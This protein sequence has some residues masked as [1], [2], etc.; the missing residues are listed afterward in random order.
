MNARATTLPTDSN[1]R[2][3]V[4]LLRG[5]LRYAPAALAGMARISKIGNDK[6]NPGEEIHHA[7][8][9]SGDH[10]DCVVRHLLDIQDLEAQI[11]RNPGLSSEKLLFEVDQFM[12]R[13]AL[14]SQMMHEKYGGA[15]M[16]PGAKS[17]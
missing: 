17:C 3:D 14:Y 9:K 6:H 7:R 11:E 5:C 10:G 16:A 15:P 13:A 1:E 4:P 2:K 12:W 8:G